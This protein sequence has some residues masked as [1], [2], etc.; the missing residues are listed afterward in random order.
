M[1]H[2]KVNTKTSQKKFMWAIEQLTGAEAKMVWTP[3]GRICQLM[4]S[5][6][7]W[8]KYCD[9]SL[10]FQKFGK[11]LKQAEYKGETI[12]SRR[13]MELCSGA[14]WYEFKSNSFYYDYFDD[15]EAVEQAINN[16]IDAALEKRKDYRS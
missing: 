15:Y 16:L 11:K 9:L 13:E 6:F 8:H 5:K 1:K 7:A 4:I 2:I 12:T 14:V 10:S 3:S